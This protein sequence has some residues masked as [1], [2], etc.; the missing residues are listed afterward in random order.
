MAPE[1]IL[2]GLLRVS[3]WDWDGGEDTRL[4]FFV[5]FVFKFFCYIL[6]ICF[7]GEEGF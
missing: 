2:G 6:S 5:G 4:T 1:G 3:A 7:V